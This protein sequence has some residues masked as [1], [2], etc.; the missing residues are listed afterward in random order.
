MAQPPAFYFGAGFECASHVRSDGVRLDLTSASQHDRLAKKDFDQVAS[1]GLRHVRDGLRWHLI[2]KK[3]HVY[4]WSSWLAM[5]RASDA[6]GVHV[7]W[8]LCHYGWPDHL[9]VWSSAFIDH[10]RRFSTA[11]AQVLRDE[12]DQLPQYCP[13][14]EMSFLAWAGGQVA[15]MNP[16]ASNRAAELKRQLVRA[17]IAS[18][19]GIRQV[20]PRSRFIVSEPLI[21]V[22]DKGNDGVGAELFRQAQFEAVDMLTGRM[23]PELGGNDRYLDRVGVNYYPHNQWY[24]NGA[25]IPFGDFSYRPLREML[26]EIA[27]RYLRPIIVSETGAEAGARPYWLHYVAAEV[28]EAQA[29]GTQIEGIFLYPIL[30]HHGWDDDRICAA[31]LLGMPDSTDQREIDAP[32]LKELKLQQSIFGTDRPVMRR[33]S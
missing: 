8:D 15:W 33:V 6:A 20:D 19:D 22:A 21:H 4:D 14:N 26:R 13:I 28:R 30:N 2:E 25:T 5:I 23:A 24:F 31:G 10:F 7:I 9:D 29:L 18:A 27:H 16:R 17:Y 32:Y 11:A 12:S 3:P 1:L